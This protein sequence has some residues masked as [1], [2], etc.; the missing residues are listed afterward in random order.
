METLSPAIAGDAAAKYFYRQLC[1]PLAQSLGAVGDLVSNA[2]AQAC[3]SG[4]HDA[5]GTYFTSLMSAEA[6]PRSEHE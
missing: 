5:L 1:A 6:A 3:S 2:A 4:Q